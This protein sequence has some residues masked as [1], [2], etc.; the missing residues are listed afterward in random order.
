MCTYKI[1]CGYLIY[2]IHTII[3][4]QYIQIYNFPIKLHAPPVRWNHK[5]N[6]N[7]MEMYKNQ[8]NKK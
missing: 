4:M 7:N 6:N 2:T 5:T 3:Y 1:K 8:I